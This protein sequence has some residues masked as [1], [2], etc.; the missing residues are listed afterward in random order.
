MIVLGGRDRGATC[1]SILL[2]VPLAEIGQF[3]A[4]LNHENL[5]CFS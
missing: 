5:V 1:L 4:E 3:M 2:A